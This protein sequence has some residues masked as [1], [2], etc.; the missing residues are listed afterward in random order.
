MSTLMV[1]GK[2][3]DMAAMRLQMPAGRNAI[4]LV[5]TLVIVIAAA[6]F[7]LLSSHSSTPTEPAPAA[8]VAPKAPAATHAAAP[9]G[10]ASGVAQT[11]AKHAVAPATGTHAAKHAHTVRPAATAAKPVI[12]PVVGGLKVLHGVAFASSFSA[13]WNAWTATRPNGAARYQLSSTAAT[14]N[15]LGIPAPG[16]VAVTIDD[17]PTTVLP[18]R[19]SRAKAGAS[20]VALIPDFV[21]V[22]SGAVGTKLA[23]PPA[24]TRLG[25]AEAAIESYAYTDSGVANV[26]VDILA[27][28]DGRFVL[29]ELDTEPAFAAAG[30]AA[31][32]TLGKHWLWR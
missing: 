15:G 1:W 26:Q 6:A 21:G 23:S 10:T 5:A 13:T 24:S 11:G 2:A 30:E 20:P 25:G 28:H 18:V 9:A 3:A 29:V 17:T 27:R 8:P 14:P 7:V 31:L 4:G 16:G 19:L 12:S 32:E 22:P